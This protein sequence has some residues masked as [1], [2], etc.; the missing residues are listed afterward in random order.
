MLRYFLEQMG[1]EA[2]RLRLVWASAAEGQYLAESIDR[3]VAD[4]Q[5]LGPLN[6]SGQLGGE[7]RAASRPW[8]K[9]SPNTPK[10]WRS[11]HERRTKRQTGPLLGRIVRRLRDRRAGDQR[12]DPRR[13]RACS[14]SSSGPWPSTPRSTTWRRC[15]TAS[16]DVCLFNGGIRTSEQEYMAQLLRRKSKV[17]VAFGSCANEGCIPGLANATSRR[18]DLRHR[19]PRDALDREPRRHRA[20]AQDRSA[21]R[22]AAPAG[23]L[24]HAADPRPDGAGGLLPARL[25]ARGRADLGRDHGHRRAA[26]CRR[27]AR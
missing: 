2:D 13:G 6:W 27:R 3:F 21:R 17:L 18:A 9:S 25:P 22:D 19:L 11:K 23:V 20:A 15:P 1:I 7:R 26:S 16:I 4:V 8:R 14:T 5:K 10:R 24:R 12:E